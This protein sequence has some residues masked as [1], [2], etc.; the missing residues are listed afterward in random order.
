MSESDCF[1]QLQ[2]GPKSGQV[3]ILGAGSTTVGRY[4]LADIVI[5]DPGVSY[6][7]AVL[8]RTRE[9]CTI[10]DL[11]SDEGTYVNGMRVGAEPVQLSPGDVISFGPHT[12]ATLGLGRSDLQ[13]EPGGKLLSEALPDAPPAGPEETSESEDIPP[14]WDEPQEETLQDHS[15]RAPIHAGPLPA[16]PPATKGKNSR[17]I[18]IS[19]GCLLLLACCCSTTLFMY[20]VGGDWL[21]RQLGYL[22]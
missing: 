10:A 12:L 14:V 17:I 8:T 21:L 22:P 20:F 1:L 2:S 7:H 16:M 6:R 13:D 18:L 5:D 4:P 3:Y 15:S 19:A 9:A 11:A